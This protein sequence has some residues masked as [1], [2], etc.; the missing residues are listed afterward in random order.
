MNLILITIDC[1]RADHISCIGYNR[2]TTPFIDSLAKNGLLFKEVIVNGAG[3][4][5]SFTSLFTSTY[6]FMRG[7][8]E[9]L[10]RK[11]IAEVLKK[12]GYT[13]AGINDN[14]YL[15][16]YFGFNRGFDYFNCLSVQNRRSH[17]AIDI[18]KKIISDL[19]MGFGSDW[20][21]NGRI[22]TKL[23]LDWIT[24]N[25]SDDFFL[26]IHYMDVHGPHYA[27]RTYYSKIGI[28]PPI[29]FDLYRLNRKLKEN[30]SELYKAGIINK[31]DIELL[32]N[33]YDAEIRYVDECIYR[34]YKELKFLN[35][36]DKTIILIT[37]DHGEEFFEHG[38]YHSNT[39]LYD[40]MIRVPLVVF[41]PNIPIRIVSSQVRQIDIA[42][43][44]L[45]LLGE[46]EE[47]EFIGKSLV[48]GNPKREYIITEAAYYE[49]SGGR[50]D[51]LLKI[52]FKLRKT[53]IRAEINGQKW[54]YI[55][56]TKSKREELYNLTKDPSENLNL[57][58][59][60]SDEVCRILE[61]MRC[62]LKNHLRHEEE[63]RQ[64]KINIRRFVKK[65]K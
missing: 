16:P 9:R 30:P 19:A 39:N 59:D 17:R 41:G 52:D 11:T 7:G 26:W 43:T 24:E 53:S 13:T 12:K 28:K 54:K 61:T 3:T 49:I 4:F 47:E 44:I 25:K 29:I 42:P 45:D 35:L 51:K 57:I 65:W 64:L 6:P 21:M 37:S 34:L 15:S 36:L 56:C 14:G 63:E 55:Y 27:P 1:L 48:N 50:S 62:I 58:N 33:T 10:N 18:L 60:E 40:E 31:K 2:N 38:D 20:S 32:K 46:G 8:F 5:A 23:A 22:V